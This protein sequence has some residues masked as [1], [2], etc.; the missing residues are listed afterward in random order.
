MKSAQFDLESIWATSTDAHRHGD[1]SDSGL[2]ASSV[3]NR[4]ES[5]PSPSEGI[6]DPL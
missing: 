4:A 5:M 3:L 2:V 6:N 1:V